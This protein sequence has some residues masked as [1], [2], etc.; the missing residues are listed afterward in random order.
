VQGGVRTPMLRM[1][2]STAPFTT[3]GTILR[4]MMTR[5]FGQGTPGSSSVCSQ[6]NEVAPGWPWTLRNKQ[7]L[8]RMD[9]EFFQM[10]ID[11]V[12][13]MWLMRTN[14]AS[15]ASTRLSLPRPFSSEGWQ[16]AMSSVTGRR[17]HPRGR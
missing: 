7:R 8:G 11:A 5:G 14:Q 1:S 13:S 6:I 16:S 10:G 15:S 17:S 9:G 4:G 12:G 3:P 2:T